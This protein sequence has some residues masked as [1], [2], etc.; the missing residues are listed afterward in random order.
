MPENGPMHWTRLKPRTT[1][2]WWHLDDEY[3][4]PCLLHVVEAD[5]ILH[6]EERSY[7]GDTYFECPVAVLTGRWSS[8]RV[9]EPLETVEESGVSG[10][11]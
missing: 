8:E 10:R 1:G 3:R 11:G 5:G 6:A 9:E 2:W 7:R 4:S